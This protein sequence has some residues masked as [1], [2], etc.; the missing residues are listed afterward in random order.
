M[1]KVFR[2][3]AAIVVLA[4]AVYLM[5]TLF[6]VFLVLAGI[7]LLYV[8]FMRFFG[9]SPKANMHEPSDG[10]VIEHDPLDSDDKSR[11]D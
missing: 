6:F 1:N 8:L 9:K 5:V 7:G 3:A 4:L 2:F 11:K 10:I